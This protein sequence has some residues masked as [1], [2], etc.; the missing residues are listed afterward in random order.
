MK[1]KK[2]LYHCLTYDDYEKNEVNMNGNLNDKG[3]YSIV[4]IKLKER[5]RAP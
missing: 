1:S 3:K 5:G 4:Y 2:C